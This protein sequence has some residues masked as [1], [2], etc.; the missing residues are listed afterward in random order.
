[1]GRQVNLMAYLDGLRRLVLGAALT[2][3]ALAC[4]AD[5]ENLSEPEPPEPP[6]VGVEPSAGCSDGVLEHGGLYRICFPADWNGDLVL[7]AHGYVA[8]QQELALPEEVVGGRTVSTLATDLGYAYATTSYRA[9]GLVAPDAV[10]D[11]LELV[12]T[13]EHQYRPDPARTVI[14]GFSEG[15]LVATLAV[16]RHPDRFAGALAGCGPIGDFR[17]QLDYIADFRVVFDYFFPGLI[18]GNALDIPASVQERWDQVYVP[19]IVLALAARPDAARDLLQ[20][21]GAPAAGEDLRSIAE[22][23]I[24]LLWYNVFG[25]ADAQTQLGG[26]PFG[27]TQRV[28]TGS[29]DDSALNA[30]VDR[31]AAEPEALA[32]IARFSTTGNILVPLVNLHTTG[33]PIVP[34]SQASL[35]AAKVDRANQAA[36]FTRID[37]DRHGHCAFEAGELLNAFVALWDQVGTPA[38]SIAGR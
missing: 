32:G 20:V 35:Y 38:A 19:A 23:T 13:V 8:P 33:D 34:F 10:A 27:N 2:F 11:L 1:M 26:Q 14:V 31:F 4:G 36:R 25:T 30:G 7:Y 12:D 37:V 22:T 17:A 9:N 5:D 24:G 16:E 18:P 15:G 28:Y 29:A 6:D 3:T 21:T